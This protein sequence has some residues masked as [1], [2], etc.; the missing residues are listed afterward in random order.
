MRI[1][2]SPPVVGWLTVKDRQG[3]E[4]ELAEL[5]ARVGGAET[6]RR[7]EAG[8]ATVDLVVPR[9]GYPAFAQGLARIGSWRPE[10][11]PPELPDS[12]PITL[13]ITQ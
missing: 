9:A 6:A 4:R 10:A 12:V 2:A 11:E 13:R 3:A 8:G 5:L 7:A 1:A